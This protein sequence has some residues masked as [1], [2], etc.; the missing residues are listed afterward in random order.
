MMLEESARV[1]EGRALCILDCSVLEKPESRMMEGLCPVRS[2]KARRIGRPRPKMG[3]GYYRGEPG[4]P[5][6]VPGFEWISA[7]IT[8]W[9]SREEKRPVALS[10]WHWYAKPV[11][12]ESQEG[13][14]VVRQRGVEAAR[15]VLKG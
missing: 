9:A 1:G 10:T 8:G 12:G 5:I 15:S 4:G 14:E 11:E 6:V 3:G 13:S 2:A 7:L